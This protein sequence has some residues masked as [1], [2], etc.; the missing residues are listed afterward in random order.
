M[1]EHWK[2]VTLGSFP[3]LVLYWYC[4]A[5]MEDDELVDLSFGGPSL[6]FLYVL[7]AHHLYKVTELG[8]T[9][10]PVPDFTWR[11]EL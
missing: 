2:L 7:S 9:G 5:E 8:V 10:N 4:V 3:L 1:V 11:P 6:D